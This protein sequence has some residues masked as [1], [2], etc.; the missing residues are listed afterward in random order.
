MN[1]S[2]QAL[3]VGAGLA[4]LALLA[5]GC[6]SGS[7]TPEVASLGTTT[8]TTGTRSSVAAGSSFVPFATCMT[9]HGVPA[10]PGQGGHGIVIQGDPGAPQLQAAQA[11]CRKL[12]PGGGPP[13]LTPAQQAARAKGMAV[14][15]TCMRKH[16]A[17]SFPDPNGQGVFPSASID[18]LD[19]SSPLFHSGYHTCKSLFPTKGPQIRFGP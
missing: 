16:G 8:A 14:F 2:G 7:K 11:A 3:S 10:S 18:Q 4:C 9:A 5:A 1:I 12:M 17:P 6:G 15:A 13:Q 19:T